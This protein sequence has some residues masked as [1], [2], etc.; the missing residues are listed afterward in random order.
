MERKKSRWPRCP[1]VPEA[2]DCADVLPSPLPLHARTYP[3]GVCSF[4]EESWYRGCAVW[5]P[6]T[7]PQPERL[8]LWGTVQVSET[9]ASLGKGSGW[10]SSRWSL[11][12]AQLLGSPQAGASSGKRLRCQ[13]R[14]LAASSK[15]AGLRVRQ[16]KWGL[17]DIVPR[18]PF[19]SSPSSFLPMQIAKLK[20]CLTKFKQVDRFSFETF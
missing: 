12:R 10:G 7:C 16:P 13:R 2:G 4:L 9:S 3:I 11:F 1:C 18:V 17:E 5:G 6:P 19:C 8:Q 20:N 15:P 14:P